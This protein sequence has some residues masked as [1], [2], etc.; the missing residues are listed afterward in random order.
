[1]VQTG[2]GRWDI[3]EE[4]EFWLRAMHGKICWRSE[5]MEAWYLSTGNQACGRMSVKIN[6]LSRL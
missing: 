3:W 1:M 6:G 4:N 5:E 2:N